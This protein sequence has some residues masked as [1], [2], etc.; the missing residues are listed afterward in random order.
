MKTAHKCIS[1]RDGFTGFIPVAID[2]GCD[3]VLQEVKQCITKPGSFVR[4]TFKLQLSLNVATQ[5]FIDASM[6]TLLHLI[7]Q[8]TVNIPTLEVLMLCC[9]RIPQEE[10]GELC[11]DSRGAREDPE[12]GAALGSHQS[13]AEGGGCHQRTS[14]HLLGR[15][16]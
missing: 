15:S 6:Y 7:A 2:K 8:M 11:A 3:F 13:Q 14:H 9:F 10:A 12:D 5:R 4:L 16:L 1:Q